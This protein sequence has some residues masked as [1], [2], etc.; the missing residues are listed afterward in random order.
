M[1]RREKD[2]KVAQGPTRKQVAY[3]KRDQ[4][5]TRRVL[6]GVAAVAALIVIVLILGIVQTYVLAPQAP[7][8]KVNGSSVSTEQYQK[9]YRFTNYQLERTLAQARQQQGVYAAD[10]QQKFMYDYLQQQIQQI[11]GQRM[12]L[13]TDVLEKMIDEELIRQEAAK[14]GITVAPEEIQKQI[15]TYFGYDRNPPTPTLT[16]SQV[17]TLTPTPTTAPMTEQEYNNIFGASIQQYQQSIGYTEADFR[18]LFS[19][20]LLR[21]KLQSL[22]ETEVPTNAEQIHVRHILITSKP[23]TDTTGLTPEQQQEATSQAERDARAK[24]EETLKRVTAGGEDFATVAKEVSDDPGSKEKGGDLDWI[25]RGDM[26][27]EFDAAAF[28]LQPGQTYTDMV[29]SRYGYH[30]I[31][32]DE[33][34]STR[35]LKEATLQQRTSQ[36]L[37]DWLQTTRE[38]AKI[39]R[40]WS[41]S[42]VPAILTPR[43]PILPS[44]Q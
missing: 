42:K 37:T 14:R 26:V 6:I 34:E 29:A 20:S 36:A 25:A 27:P 43:A 33:R 13:P 24:A 41:S 2:A 15:E 32:V 5:R 39:E 18:Q 3:R 10:E 17:I 8:A 30:I 22:L 23:P 28:T 11:E 21:D 7:V 12:T 40:F 38:T 9:A 16:A 4:E 19:D 31:K 1:T 44:G 35:P